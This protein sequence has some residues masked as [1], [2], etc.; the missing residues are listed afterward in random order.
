MFY[1]ALLNLCPTF[2]TLLSAL[3]HIPCH[4]STEP[5]SISQTYPESLPICI[6]QFFFPTI[7]GLTPADVSVNIISSTKPS[8][9]PQPWILPPTMCY[10]LDPLSTPAGKSSHCIRI[11]C[12]VVCISLWTVNSIDQG[13]VFFLFPILSQMSRKYVGQSRCAV[14]FI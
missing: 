12:T 14:M 1:K 5:C 9:V 2:L 10:H 11:V 6:I 7:F 8:L 3:L 13:T 4:S